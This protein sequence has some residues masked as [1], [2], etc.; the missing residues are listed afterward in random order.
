MTLLE[1]LVLLLIAGVCGAVGQA[2]VGTS[3]GFLVSIAVGFVGALIGTWLARLV[4]LPELFAVRVGDTNFPI[5]WSI[6]GAT[7]LLAVVA[8]LT[9]STFV[10]RRWT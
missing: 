10:R 6:L 4:G 7:L 9:G 3:R 8:L 5:V 1:F 2:I